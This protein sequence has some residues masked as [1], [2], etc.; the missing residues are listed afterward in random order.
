MNALT[1]L[2]D[3]QRAA[4]Y[5]MGAR[6]AGSMRVPDSEAGAAS[7]WRIESVP[8]RHYVHVERA[9][10]GRPVREARAL[11]VVH[12]IEAMMVAC[13]LDAR[14]AV[15]VLAGALSVPGRRFRRWIQ[16]AV[17]EG[18]L[19][20]LAILAEKYEDIGKDGGS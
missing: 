8:G 12:A 3:E 19:W 4:A 1:A 13:D 7:D 10:A 11:L 16:G 15:R 14:T 17:D 18:G 2:S 5:G 6:R 9:G 20:R